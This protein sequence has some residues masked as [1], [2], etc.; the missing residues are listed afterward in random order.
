[1]GRLKNYQQDNCCQ[2][3]SFPSSL[4]CLVLL[5]FFSAKP[6][7]EFSRLS[8]SEHQKAGIQKKYIKCVINYIL[9]YVFI[10][11]NFS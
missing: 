9:K 7:I 1:M 2:K 4:V 6:Q 3:S 5:N 11:S 10:S 8:T